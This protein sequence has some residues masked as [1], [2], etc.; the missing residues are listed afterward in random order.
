MR[1]MVVVVVLCLHGGAHLCFDGCKKDAG[2]RER[3]V[4]LSIMR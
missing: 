3:E 2:E 4:I 1:V